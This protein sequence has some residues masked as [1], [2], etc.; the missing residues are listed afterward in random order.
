LTKPVSLGLGGDSTQ[1]VSVTASGAATGGDLATTAVST[2]VE[3]YDQDGAA[4]PQSGEPF[5]PARTALRWRVSWPN[6][7]NRTF[8]LSGL[9]F[10]LPRTTQ[11]DGYVGTDV[12]A[13]TEVSDTRVEVAHEGD[14]TRERLT[15]TLRSCWRDLSDD[16]QPYMAVRLVRDG[17]TVFRGVTDDRT[18]W[19]TIAD[20]VPPTG[21]LSLQATGL[22]GIFAK[23]PWPGGEPFDG[24]LATDCIAEVLQ[25]GGMIPEQ[26]DLAAWDFVFPAVPAGEAPALVY[27]PGTKIEQLLQDIAEKFYGTSHRHYFRVSDGKF[28]LEEVTTPTLAATFYSSSFDATANGVPA[29]TIR[30]GSYRIDLDS[31]E[32]ANVIGVIGE[33]AN[34]EPL[35]ATCIDWPS[36]KGYADGSKPANYVRGIILA[37]IVVDPG[38]RTEEAVKRVARSL[39]VRR[40]NPRRLAQ[41]QSCWV[42][43]LQVGD[44]VYLAGPNYDV[45]HVLRGIVG[46]RANDGDES[47]PSGL[48]SY[49]AEVVA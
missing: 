10:K 4:W 36:I 25:A 14:L 12:I 23:M 28:V 33:D 22:W 24:R 8:A 42:D 2:T 47:A 38:L 6:D 43:G 21:D 20:T 46:A 1:P 31:S 44:H 13:L 39:Y 27:K 19:T 35:V 37:L 26:Y 18:S 48:A 34:G 32:Q 41:W 30:D 45:R 16:C 9:D 17:T 3:V 40:R 29:Q 11:L 7:T 49:S 15:A 5:D